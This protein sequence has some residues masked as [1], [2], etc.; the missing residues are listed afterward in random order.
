[1]IYAWAYE[2]ENT[3]SFSTF[4]KNALMVIFIAVALITCLACDYTV[5]SQ[6]TKSI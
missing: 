6:S 1:V 3:E 5:C 4:K 2:K